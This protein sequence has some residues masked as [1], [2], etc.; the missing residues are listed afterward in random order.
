MLYTRRDVGKVALA[1]LP[2]AKLFG[3]AKINSKFGGVQIGTISY[4]L[5]ASPADPTASSRLWSRSG[6]AKWN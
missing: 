1:T 6:W 5:T 2:M 4:S 3:A